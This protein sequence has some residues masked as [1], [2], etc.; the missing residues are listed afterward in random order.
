MK[1]E[2]LSESEDDPLDEENEEEDRAA[3]EKWRKQV[4]SWIRESMSPAKKQKKD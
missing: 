2:T 1:D 3:K 4:D